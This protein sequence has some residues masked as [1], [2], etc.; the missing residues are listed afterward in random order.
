M[1]LDLPEGKYI[2]IIENMGL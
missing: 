2:V 1:S